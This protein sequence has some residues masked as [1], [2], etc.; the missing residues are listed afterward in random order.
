M[1]IYMYIPSLV[2]FPPLTIQHFQVTKDPMA[3]LPMLYSSFPL[4]TYFTHGSVYIH[5]DYTHIH[6]AVWQ[7]PTQHCKAIILQ[8]KISKS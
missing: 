7:K 5:I 6:I 3:G 2:S 1:S 4:V 8:L